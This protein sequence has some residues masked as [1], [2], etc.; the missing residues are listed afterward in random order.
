MPMP[1]DFA[2]LDTETTG[3][4]AS[5]ERVI[6]V[7]II[8][9]RN[10]EVVE[11]YQ[12]LINPGQKISKETRQITKITN[13]MVED[14]P[15]FSQIAG[16][17]RELLRGAI[18]VAHNVEFDYGFIG[19]EFLRIGEKFQAPRLCTVKLSQFIYSGYTRHNLD[20]IAAR[21]RIDIQKRHRAYDDAKAIFEFYKAAHKYY[22]ED[23]FKLALD[24]LIKHPE[25]VSGLSQIVAKQQLSLI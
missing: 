18:F 17:V 9:V 24:R 8:R 19:H 20:S 21:M 25:N 10:G 1:V 7:G 11:E 5:R 12:T 6:D 4:D 3:F 2:F 15:D 23:N 14:A 22:G 13:K 16:K